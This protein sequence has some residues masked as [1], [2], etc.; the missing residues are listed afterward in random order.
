MKTDEATQRDARSSY[1][2]AASFVVDASVMPDMATGNISA[3]AVII[4]RRTAELPSPLMAEP[5]RRILDK[6]VEIEYGG[7]ERRGVLQE[8]WFRTKNGIWAPSGVPS[9]RSDQGVHRRQPSAGRKSGYADRGDT[10]VA[11][12]RSQMQRAGIFLD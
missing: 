3:A 1:N 9:D 8:P 5:S 2:K 10:K 7:A 4:A 11:R 6:L 12:R